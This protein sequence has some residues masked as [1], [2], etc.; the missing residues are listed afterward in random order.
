ML[1]MNFAVE[2]KSCLDQHS[3]ARTCQ[4]VSRRHYDCFV[5]AQIWSL[6]ATVKFFY[7]HAA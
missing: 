2:S 1:V 6:S 5:Y 3:Q 7:C 4:V